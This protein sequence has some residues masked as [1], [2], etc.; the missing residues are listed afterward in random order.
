VQVRC[1]R[2]GEFRM[3]V[4]LAPDYGHLP[5]KVQIHGRRGDELVQV[6]SAMKVDE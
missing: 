3:D 5:V 4:W 6:L 2:E 1:E